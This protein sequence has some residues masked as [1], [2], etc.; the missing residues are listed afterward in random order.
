M[1]ISIRSYERQFDRL[2]VRVI[3][4]ITLFVLY[5]MPSAAQQ[6][7]DSVVYDFETKKY[8]RAPWEREKGKVS[9]INNTQYLIKVINVDLTQYEFTQDETV[10]TDYYLTTPDVLKS[11]KIPA[12]ISNIGGGIQILGSNGESYVFEN[13]IYSDNINDGLD[14]YNQLRKRLS[15]LKT[16]NQFVE[17]INLDCRSDY[18]NVQKKILVFFKQEKYHST[19]DKE[20]IEVISEVIGNAYAWNSRYLRSYDLIL[21]NATNNIDA[22]IR[23]SLA[24]LSGQERVNLAKVLKA[25]KDKSL[26]DFALLKTAAEAARKDGLF[27]K[28]KKNWSR[29][30][31]NNFTWY[32]K[33]FTANK[34]EINFSLDIKAKDN[35]CAASRNSLFLNET[36]RVRRGLKVDFSSGIFVNM[37]NADFLGRNFEYKKLPG[38]STQKIVESKIR[39]K[40]ILSLGALTHFYI[41][42]A[43]SWNMGL[44]LGASANTDLDNIQLHAGPSILFRQANKNRFILSGGATWRSTEL[45]SPNYNLEEVALTSE[46]PSDV[47]TVKQ[48][49]C[50]G[51]FLSLTYNLISVN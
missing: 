8:I 6:K 48:N 24:G 39:N 29:Y 40:A 51:W 30:T 45:L 20:Y 46:F 2:N 23:N 13:D 15:A 11:I 7:V 33:P 22:D 49:F 12:S 5:H 28:L 47:P 32:G 4:C 36:I 50:L 18:I 43:G 42:N 27:E 19:K 17:L 34:D 1:K 14:D 35:K 16:I 31:E 41:R 25:K 26:A 10:K 9:F 44:S 21:K 38:D 3:L 37:G